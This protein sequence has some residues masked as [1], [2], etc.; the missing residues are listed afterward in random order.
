MKRSK[1]TG[2]EKSGNR[3]AASL[4]EMRFEA[5]IYPGRKAKTK[6]WADDQAP[7]LQANGEAR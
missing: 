3:S 4:L 7:P 6:E 1:S 5:T 2:E